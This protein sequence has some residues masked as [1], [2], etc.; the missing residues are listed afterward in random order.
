[1]GDD[2]D[3]EWQFSLSDLPDEDGP[4]EDGPAEDGGGN[5]AGAVLGLEE[6][7]EPG[8]IDPENAVFVLL[9]AAVAVVVLLTMA[10]VI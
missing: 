10:G 1:M 7:V 3:D 6:R 9:G 2:E 8:T 5:V 4:A